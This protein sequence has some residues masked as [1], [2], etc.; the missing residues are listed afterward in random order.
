MTISKGKCKYLH[1]VLIIFVQMSLLDIPPS[2]FIP[3]AIIQFDYT[4]FHKINGEWHNSFFDLVLPFLREP[5][6]WVPLYFFL[7]VFVVINFRSKGLYW[8]LFFIVNA[9]MSDLISSRLVKENF[10]RLRPCRDPLISDTVRFIAEYCPVSSSFT[11]SH[12]TNHFA[13]A[14]FIFIT[15]RKVLNPWWA[16]VFLWAFAICYAQV[17]VGVHFP[18]DVI[19]G[20]ILGLIIGYIP[21]IIFKRKIGL[22][23]I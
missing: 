13:V 18:T 17:Y 20:A 16:L 8:V 4:L 2:A 1:V 23:P 21:S 5:M 22:L 14:M 12:A 6:F 9:M 10:F 19:C 7:A 11:S 3:N 15:F